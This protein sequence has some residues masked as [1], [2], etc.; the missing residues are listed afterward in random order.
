M[1]KFLFTLAAMLMAGSLFAQDNYLYV[2][3]MELTQEE[4]T[5]G[6]QNKAIFVVAHFE[7]YVTT[8]DFQ[9]QL[10]EGMTVVSS[11]MPNA[12]KPY[13][14]QYVDVEDD[15][16]NITSELTR[17]RMNPQV[18]G[19]YPH[20]IITTSLGAETD[21]CYNEDGSICYGAPKWGVDPVEFNFLRLVV[22]IEPGFNGGDVLV[23]TEPASTPDPRGNV[24]PKGTEYDKVNVITVQGGGEPVV[25]DAPEIVVTAG[26][27][28]YVFDVVGPEGAELKLFV[29]GVEVEI[30]YTVA[31]TDAD[32][33]VKL[34][35]TSHIEGQTD[36]T[37]TGEYLVPALPVVEPEDLTGEI[38]I[39]DPDENGN[40]TINYTGDENVTIVVTVNG[41]V[42]EVVDGV[43]TVGEGESEIIVTVTAEGYN[44]MTNGKTV[45]YTVPVEPEQTEAPVI[46]TEDNGEAVVVT[47][48]GNGHICIYWD[49][50]L[51][52]EGEGT[53]TWTIPY[54][55]DPEGEEYG[56][57]AT[58]QEEGKLVSDYA[59]A[60][61]FVPGKAVEPQ[62]TATPEI[63]YVVTDNEV[64]ITVTGEGEIHVYV[65]GVEVDN[66]ATIVRGEEDQTVVVTATAQAE[67]QL[68]SETA[69]EE[70]VIP[71]YVDDPEG[72]MTG[73]WVVLLDK[74]GAEVWVKLENTNTEDPNQY[75]ANVALHYSQFGGQPIGEG[76]TDDDNPMVPFYFMI[77][78][79]RYACQGENVVP[80]YGNANE[81]PLY[82]TEN[83]WNVNVGYYY[84]V[85]VLVDPATGNKYLQ[86]SKGIYTGI[87]EMN[88]DKTV[89]A[90]RY[91]NMAGQEMQEANGMTIVVTTYTD[92]TTSAVK[93]M[94]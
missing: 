28:A 52:A 73:Y 31:R 91:F 15:E 1:K 51:M 84:T 23:H 44:E 77:D 64:I 9:V 18:F 19:A 45:T 20:W 54:G 87:D 13:V 53:A 80:V 55:E 50:Q 34:T 78:G 89:A 35:A 47:A 93:V 72:H 75:L 3:D 56:V 29:D 8:V 48:T 46:T 36:G 85:G 92:G 83:F 27:D 10:P 63:S 61:V 94:K 49:D 76:M 22:N 43:I 21:N 26:D 32:Q 40:V 82:E 4:A 62:P 16:G 66:P 5:N 42:V 79:D 57:S 7:S 33:I 65:D 14:Y 11:S 38:V 17:Q 69:T 2:P 71:A 24:C 68:I 6:V 74:N 12:A 25:T 30:P 67:G 37:V 41:E 60:T 58:A 59:L 90:V 86:I 70:I 88:A 39:G 81:N